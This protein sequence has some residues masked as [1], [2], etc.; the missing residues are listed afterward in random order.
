MA[1]I[2]NNDVIRITAK[3]QIP[4]GNVQNV[5][6][7]RF[8]GTSGADGDTVLADIAT[9]LDTA[10]AEIQ[11]GLPNTLTFE[12]IEAFNISADEP[13]GEIDW[14]N[15]TVGGASGQSLPP[16]CAPLV[17]F[18]TGAPR[19]QGRKYL[20]AVTEGETDGGG[21]LTAG[22]LAALADFAAFLLQAVTT[23]HG[24]VVPGNWSK[25]YTRFAPWISAIIQSKLRTQRRRVYQIGS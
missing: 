8:S 7:Y 3:M 20:P 18:G 25:L 1:T 12:T 6:H 17:L 24:Y 13:I 10:Y 14:P 23:E 15:L 16:Q 11:P 9:A 22:F 5:Y 21:F 2:D 4:A 19:S